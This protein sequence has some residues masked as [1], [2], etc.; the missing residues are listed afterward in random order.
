[1]TAIARNLARKLNTYLELFPA[2]VVLGVRQCGKT[3]LAR[4]VRPDWAYF[5]LERGQDHD[6]VTRD[7]GF[8]FREYPGQ[9]IL[10]EAQ[11]SPELFRELRGVI[12]RDRAR[13]N[14][15]LLTGSSSPQL[16]SSISDSLAGRVGI[17]ELGTLKMNE[18]REEP[19]PPIYAGL[20]ELAPGEQLAGL[21]DLRG[22]VPHGHVMARFL[23]GGY[24]EPTTRRDG[25]FFDIWMQNYVQTY[26]QRDIRR[27]FPGLDIHAYRRFVGMLAELSGTILNRAEVGRSLGVSEATVRQYLDIAQGTFLWRS[28]PSCERTRS[29]SIVKMPRGYIRDCGLLHH[30][31]GIRTRDQLLRHPGTGAAFEAFVMEELI[32]GLAAAST[33]QWSYSYF[34]TRNG[35]EVDLIVEGDRLLLPIEI[36]FGTTTKGHQLRALSQ[37]VER[38]QCPY[39]ILINNSD[40][41]QMLA[42]RIIQIPAGLI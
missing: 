31:L 23:Q 4:M 33:R 30:L 20:S 36:K 12:D 37:F 9:V 16:L 40:R 35:A 34:R 7:M 18:C 26:V 14:R 6:L 21:R 5:D 8:F 13:R 22:A 28:L 19:L 1:M 32:S 27:L 10:D 17:L 38:E 41:V 3:T 25:E 2:V 24:P 39:G 11:E 29:K 15:F 42:E